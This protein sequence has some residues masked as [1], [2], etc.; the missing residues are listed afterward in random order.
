MLEM[1]VLKLY[2]VVRLTAFF[3]SFNLPISHS[4]PLVSC[5]PLRF[6]CKSRTAGLAVGH[7]QTLH[8]PR[9]LSSTLG[10][11]SNDPP[12]QKLFFP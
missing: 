7:F 9:A 10:R 12:K 2:L 6:P 11:L 1:S 4:L 3:F 5:S 8:A